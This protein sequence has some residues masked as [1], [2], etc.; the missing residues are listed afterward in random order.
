VIYTNTPMLTAY[1]YSCTA[2]AKDA[3]EF[4]TLGQ[5]FVSTVADVH[6]TEFEH[7]PICTTIYA[8]S[9]SSVD[10]VYDNSKIKYSFTAELR[11]T[12]EYGF[13]LPPGQIRPASEVRV[14][15]CSSARSITNS[16]I[17][18]FGRVSNTSWITFKLRRFL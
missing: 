9:G 3:A 1:G 12:G 2:K 16:F 5:G 4:N 17:R 15:S 10:Y 7:G 14:I 18:R 8:A 11:D 13:V 6:G